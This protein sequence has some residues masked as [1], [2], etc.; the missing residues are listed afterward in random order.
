MNLYR[1]DVSHW[2]VVRAVY[3]L[4]GILILS[5][6][7]LAFVLQQPWWLALATLVGLMQISFALTGYCPAAMVLQKA[8]ISRE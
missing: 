8:G 2:Y 7:G 5:S 1:L 6:I 3:L 4:A